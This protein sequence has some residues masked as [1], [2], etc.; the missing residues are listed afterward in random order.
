[1]YWKVLG[2]VLSHLKTDKVVRNATEVSPMTPI[3]AYKSACASVLKISYVPIHC[4]PI[5]KTVKIYII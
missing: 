5:Y 3:T 4:V 1:M 2:T